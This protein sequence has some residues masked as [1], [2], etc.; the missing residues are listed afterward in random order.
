MTLITLNIEEKF[1]D[2]KGV[3]KRCKTKKDRQYTGQ[4]KKDRRR[5][6]NTLAKRKK[7]EEETMIY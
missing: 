2:T 6:D 4:K 7:T 5:T 3:I 1:E